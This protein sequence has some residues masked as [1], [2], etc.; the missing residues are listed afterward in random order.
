MTAK[1]LKLRGKIGI[2]TAYL[3]VLSYIAYFYSYYELNYRLDEVYF[4]INT[5]TTSIWCYLLFQFFTNKDVKV[6]FLFTSVFAG[7]LCFTYVVNWIIM[8]TPYTLIKLSLIAGFSIALIYYLYGK[9]IAK[10]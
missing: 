2:V 9:F 8:G 7:G 6:A 4:S 1:N 5:I 3:F 10:H